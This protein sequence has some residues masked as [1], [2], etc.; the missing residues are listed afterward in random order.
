[1]GKSVTIDESVSLVS[2]HNPLT[3]QQLLAIFVAYGIGCGMAV[4]AF[5]AERMF[6][7][8]KSHAAKDYAWEGTVYVTKNKLSKGFHY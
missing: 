3:L 4:L 1:M 2:K 7:R 5:L 6:N 8:R